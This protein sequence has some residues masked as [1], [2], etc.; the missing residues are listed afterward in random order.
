MVSLI[1]SVKYRLIFFCTE[2]RKGRNKFYFF[3]GKEK[4]E[5]KGKKERTRGDREK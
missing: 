3:K 1:Y 5:V 4:M 2:K